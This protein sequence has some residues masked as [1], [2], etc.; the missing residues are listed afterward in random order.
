TA[1]TTTHGPRG[2]I[3][4]PSQITHFLKSVSKT[5][6]GELLFP[7]PQGPPKSLVERFMAKCGLEIAAQ[8]VCQLADWRA[9][10]VMR[11]AFDPIRRFARFGEGG[12]WP[13][14][15]RRIYAAD[16]AFPSAEGNP[17]QI[18]HEESL[19]YSDRAELYAVVVIFGVELCINLGGPEL[20]G[21]IDWLK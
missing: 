16:T 7:I 10:T 15:V 8:S 4:D 6:C 11:A 14:H 5:G 18:I 20:D 2:I 12:E 9:Q 13:V 17:T 3:I 1:Y 21:Y 19:L